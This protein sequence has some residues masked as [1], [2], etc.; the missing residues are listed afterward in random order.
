MTEN[1]STI[2]G[3]NDDI[4]LPDGWENDDSLFTLPE[5]TGYSLAPP[6]EVKEDKPAPDAP[7]DTS[8]QAEPD[9]TDAAPDGKVDSPDGVDTGEKP[10]DVQADTPEEPPKYKYTIR[11]NHKNQEIELTEAELIARLQKSYAADEK[12]SRERYRTVY[13]EQI[14]AGM[15]EAAARLIAKDA[16]NGKQ[17]SID[18]SGDEDDT[19]RD[20]EDNANADGKQAAAETAREAGFRAELQQIKDIYPDFDTVP[21]AVLDEAAEGKSLLAAYVKYRN[22]QAEK[23]SAESVQ[24]ET[25]A[26]QKKNAALTQRIRAA[27]QAPVKGVS[28]G[29]NPSA[30]EQQA[31][32]FMSGF[33]KDGW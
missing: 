26:L 4:I 9:T 22:A 25:A 8:T 30:P 28:S 3:L 15:S 20:D 21:K 31:D 1:E 7:A 16:A 18:D 11:V 2:N 19:N 14:S 12:A 24:K 10:E 13:H 33:D 27:Q 23:E 6:D 5:D 29:G 32:P 17:Y